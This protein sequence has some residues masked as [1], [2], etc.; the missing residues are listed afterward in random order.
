MVLICGDGHHGAAQ[1][2][3][4]AGRTRPGSPPGRRGRDR[5]WFA[6][7]PRLS[8][9]LGDAGATPTDF[10]RPPSRRPPALGVV[11]LV[12]LSSG[13]RWGAWPDRAAAGRALLRVRVG[14]YPETLADCSPPGCAQGTRCPAE[15]R[16]SPWDRSRSSPTAR[17]EHADGVVPRAVRRGRLRR[18]PADE[19]TDLLARAS[20]GGLEVATHAI[21]RRGSVGARR[22]RHRRAGRSSTP[23]WSRA[24]T[25]SPCPCCRGWQRWGCARASGHLLD[26]RD[27][28]EQVWADRADRCFMLRSMSEAGVELAL[29]SDAPVARL[30]P[31]L[32]I[33]AA[34]HRS[35][36]ARDAW[37]PE[38]SL[39]AREALAA[40]VD[41]RRVRPGA[42]AD[43]VLLGADPL[44]LEPPAAGQPDPRA[45]TLAQTG[46]TAKWAG[47]TAD[48]AESTADQAESTADQAAHLRSLPVLATFV[49]GQVVHGPR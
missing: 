44:A 39:T 26:D 17:A 14:T 5:G 34:V 32:A 27:L 30:D 28:T 11:G 35:A 2:D 49:A 21:G 48:Q 18:L 15:T 3:R 4:G 7:Y 46:S 24:R 10:F 9:L 38:Q 43:L 19:L 40:S 47:S 1:L 12:D 6:A 37:H 42:P 22:L 36:D 25:R 33:A 31:W 41:G 23:S 13:S 20:A 45:A 16:G 29:G 8:G